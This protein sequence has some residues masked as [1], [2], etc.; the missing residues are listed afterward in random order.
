MHLTDRINAADGHSHPAATERPGSQALETLN[1]RGTPGIHPTSIGH[2]G[3][4][5]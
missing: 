3:P 5:P 4:F 1:T 2:F